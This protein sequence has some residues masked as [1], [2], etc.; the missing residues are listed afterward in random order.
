LKSIAIPP[1][2]SDLKEVGSDYRVLLEAMAP[3]TNRLIAAYLLA[4]DAANLRGG[5]ATGPSRYALVETLRRS[6]F[7]EVD[8]ASFKQISAT[9]AKQ[10]GT[11]QDSPL[12]DV[13]QQQDEINH[14]LKAL[15]VTDEV[16]LDKP[17]QLGAFF[18]EPNAYCFG[19]IGP[20]SG[21]GSSMKMVSAV[22]TLRVQDRLLYA[23]VYATYAGDD[24]V[25]WVRDTSEQ[26]ADAIL[27]AN[28]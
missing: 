13:K 14:K 24:S 28:Q 1:P 10:Y 5:I 27:K 12:T 23:Y 7:A 6:E 18:S 21:G 8:A 16:A 4:G 22:I 25:R 2:A 26:W 11:S 20:I 19:M 3:D 15:G 9:L 17:V